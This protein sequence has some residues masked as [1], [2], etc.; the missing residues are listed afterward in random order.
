MF[1][2]LRDCVEFA[3][4][5]GHYIGVR[6]GLCDVLCMADCRKIV[7]YETGAPLPP[8]LAEPIRKAINAQVKIP[9]LK[10]K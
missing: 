5:A 8:S 2:E 7:I 9:P 4:T 1:I 3:E 6:N 10:P